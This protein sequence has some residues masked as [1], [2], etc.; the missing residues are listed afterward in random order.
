MDRLEP[1]IFPPKDET[2]PATAIH[3]R[4]DDVQMTCI[5]CALND[6]RAEVERLWKDTQLI[7]SLDNSIIE[8]QQEAL[9]RVVER[10]EI[11]SNAHRRVKMPGEKAYCRLCDM[12]LDDPQCFNEKA[13]KE[14]LAFAASV[15]GKE[16]Q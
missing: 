15:M 7:D 6:L 2:S 14:A 4:H 13:D 5:A 9:R 16:A 8:K 12:Y 10:L 3:H 11:Y 1:F